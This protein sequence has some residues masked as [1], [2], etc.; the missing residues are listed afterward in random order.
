MDE[1]IERER[2][3]HGAY[4]ADPDATERALVEKLVELAGKREKLMDLAA[5]GH[6]ARTRS[7]SGPLPSTRRRP[8]SSVYFNAPATSPDG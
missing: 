4:A 3:P 5:T 8:R 7:L 6:S 1:A 2:A